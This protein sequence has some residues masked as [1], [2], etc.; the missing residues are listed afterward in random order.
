M[1][2]NTWIGDLREVLQEQS[3]PL[4]LRNGQW[5]VS[6]RK[7]LFES[8][9]SRIFDA[10]LDKFKACA[11]EVLKEL[12]PQFELPAEERYVAS[13][14]GKILK[15]S[16]GLRKGIAETLALLG[17]YGDKLVNVSRYKAELIAVLT[18]R[19]I[20]K[21]ADW[22]LWGSIN[23]LLPTL[24]EAAPDEFL[25]QVE[26][27]LQQTPC[28]FDN[29]FAQEGKGIS[30]RNYMTGLL[31]AL[32]SLS[33]SDK[34]LT[35]S[36][37]ILAELAAHDPGGRW[38]NR[39]ANSIVQILLPWYP[40]TLAPIDKR[41][42]S[43]KAIKADFPDVAWKVVI[44]FLPNQH[45]TSSGAYKPRWHITLPEDWQ[46]KVTNQEYWDQVTVYAEFAI[47]IARDNL[48][49]LKE[50]VSNI[51]N[52]PKPSFD[53]LLEHLAS[54]AVAELSEDQRLPIW[55][56]LMD[57]V[58]KHRKFADAKW[59]LSSDKVD[60]IETT[61]NKL[62]PQSLEGQHQRLFSK[63][64][65]DLYDERGNW[66]EQ[67]KKLDDKRFQAVRAL[68]HTSGLQGI[69][70]FAATVESPN[71]IGRA[72]GLID[73]KEIDI[74][75]LPNYLDNENIK[76]R[77][78]IASFIL[79]RFHGRGWAW[80]DAIDRSR[81]SLAQSCQFLMYLPFETDAWVRA[82]QWLGTYEQTYWQKVP[83][84]PYQT[85]SDPLYAIDKLLEVS[86]PLSAIGCLYSRLFNKM[87]LDRARTV[88]ALL[89]A[90]S[91]NEPGQSMDSYNITELIKALQNDPQAQD[92]DLFKVEWA[93][94]PLLTRP[95]GA[96]PK[97]LE[98]RLATK[99]EF[100]VEVIRLIYRSKNED[101][102]A[103]EVDE[104]KAAIA[105]N[106]WRL[107]HEWRR[108]PG[109]QDD[110]SFSVEEFESWFAIV[111]KQCKDS[112]HLAVAMIHVGGVLL[113]CPADPDGLWIDQAIARVLNARDAED[114]RRGFRTEV[115]NSRGVHWVDPTGKPEYELAAE[116]LNKAN[117]V[118]AAGFA[119]FA[120]TL[121][122]LSESYEREAKQIIDEHK[123]EEKIIKKKD[124]KA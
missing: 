28:P 42:S 14:Q 32:E 88:R 112:G 33:W 37:V 100:F 65:F 77:Q 35:R 87:P 10:H 43:I 48:D 119:R 60:Q 55:I 13:I 30:G 114:L 25:S 63:R 104:K 74:G 73:E 17:N 117:A 38:A 8:F 113:N 105:S 6:D 45:Q 75:L 47:E 97:L 7:M 1:D 109:L 110:G 4:S 39:P 102:Q 36:I 20:F 124:D 23:D 67:R 44:A 26:D 52:L 92:N 123:S 31:W 18:I 84:N 34:Y 82:T 3:N 62:A 83:V 78:F 98:K 99:P 93:Y 89:D 16:L 27:A 80:V 49:R 106:A 40:Q 2:Y 96:E 70:K 24:A 46:P 95:D 81:W 120:A 54:A 57:F 64:D 71:Q 66:E 11:V 69:L 76:Y 29:L 121:R 107:L 5:A 86:R 103:E 50:L 41:I 19:D 61:A 58:Q 101:Q 118:E 56:S 21:Q 111:K 91:A 79:S 94:L 15:H 59:A 116:W 108:P 51:D 115:H 85:E 9:G 90:V 68:I 53:V 12:D 122:E 22:K 72:L